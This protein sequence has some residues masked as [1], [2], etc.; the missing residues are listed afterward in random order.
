MCILYKVKT[1]VIPK[2]KLILKVLWNYEDNNRDISRNV[3]FSVHNLKI[4]NITL[5][6][7]HRF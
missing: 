6:I 3:L 2:F 5:G 1:A 4:M 7:S